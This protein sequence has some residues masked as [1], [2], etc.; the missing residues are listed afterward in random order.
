M[1]DY[2]YDYVLDEIEIGYKLSLKGVLVAIPGRNINDVKNHSKILHVF[3]NYIIIKYLY[4]NVICFLIFVSFIF[5]IVILLTSS[6]L[7][8]FKIN[9]CP[10]VSNGVK[11]RFKR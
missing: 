10:H 11:Y 9:W 7:S 8:N 3:V 6:F 4:A 5:C 2:D 1:A